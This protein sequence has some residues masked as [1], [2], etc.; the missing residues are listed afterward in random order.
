MSLRGDSIYI[1]SSLIHDHVLAFRALL[2]A[3]LAGFRQTHTEEAAEGTLLGMRFAKPFVYFSES[4]LT[5]SRTVGLIKQALDEINGTCHVDLKY[6]WKEAALSVR[7]QMAFHRQTGYKGEKYHN[8]LRGVLDNVSNAIDFPSQASRA[9]FK[10]KLLPLIKRPQNYYVPDYVRRF[11]EKMMENEIGCGV[12][13]NESHFYPA[14]LKYLGLSSISPVILSS[15][16][17]LFKP[18]P[19][20]WQKAIEKAPAA[21]KH[22]LWFIGSSDS[23]GDNIKQNPYICCAMVKPDLEVSDPLSRHCRIKHLDELLPA[24]VG[25]QES[26]PF[27]AYMNSAADDLRRDDDIEDDDVEMT[28]HIPIKMPPLEK[29]EFNIAD[30]IQ[31][32]SS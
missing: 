10:T 1:V 24:L 28:T 22:D 23:P 6:L 19:L 32:Y 31:K 26:G 4:I 15:G 11:L 18:L 8:W 7:S 20:I 3:R 13:A 29:K 14:V 16:P 30:L 17:T 12:I 25:A 2:Q 9:Q 27:L 5:P 21:S